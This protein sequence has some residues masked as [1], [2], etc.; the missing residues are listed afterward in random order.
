MGAAEP[1]N[2]FRL[3]PDLPA[4]D[5]VDG[6]P[7]VFE[8]PVEALQEA[9]ARMIA[10]E[11]RVRLLQRDDAART[12]EYEVRSRFLRFPDRVSVRFVPLGAARST[13]ALFSRSVY[14]YYDFGVNERRVRRWAR[15]LREHIAD[16]PA[17][18]APA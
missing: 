7:P 4:G 14:G 10:D 5:R 1:P 2:R 8:V 15:R 18:A 12:L 11:P 13:I 6:G 16:R 3:G 17:G 9:W